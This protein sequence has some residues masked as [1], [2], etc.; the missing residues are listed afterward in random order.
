MAPDKIWA[1]ERQRL[2]CLDALWSLKCDRVD[3]AALRGSISLRQYIASQFR[4][5]AAKALYDYF[6]P[7]RVLDLARTKLFL[8]Q[9]LL[10]LMKAIHTRDSDTYFEAET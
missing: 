2:I 4:P 8:A 6:Q 9:P 1:D 7:N 3:T 10:V 5:S